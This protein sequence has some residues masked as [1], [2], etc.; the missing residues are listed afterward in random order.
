M[1]IFEALKQRAEH[2]YTEY[3]NEHRANVKKA[4]ETMKN[5]QEAMDF[6]GNNIDENMSSVILQLDKDIEMHDMSKFSKEEFDGYRM[7]WHPVTPEEKESHKED[8][9]KAWRHHYTNNLHHWDWY[10]ENNRMDSMPL[11]NVVHMICDW[12]AMSYKKGGTTKEWYSKEKKDIHLGDRQRKF[13][14]GLIDIICK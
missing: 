8:Y 7:K 2:E 13:A 12:E 4:W 3:I 14:E 1:S 9:E 6:I 5:N 10:Y 11:I